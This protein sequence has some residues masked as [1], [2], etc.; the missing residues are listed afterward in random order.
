MVG[1][2]GLK[3]FMQRGYG[4]R[5]RHYLTRLEGLVAVATTE[6]AGLSDRQREGSTASF[7]RLTF[8]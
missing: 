8:I 7:A 3:M 4:H 5:E 2:V 6:V 1:V